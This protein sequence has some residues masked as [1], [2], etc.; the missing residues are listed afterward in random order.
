MKMPQQ[1]VMLVQSNEGIVLD[2]PGELHNSVEI[3][4]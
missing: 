2:K 1:N 3:F 4:H